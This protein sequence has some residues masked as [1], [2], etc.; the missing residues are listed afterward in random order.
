MTVSSS[1]KISAPATLAP[2]TYI[3]TGTAK[4]KLGD[5]CKWSF[6][7]TVGAVVLG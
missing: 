4:D 7:L 2:A 3:V 5:S 1:G 6:T